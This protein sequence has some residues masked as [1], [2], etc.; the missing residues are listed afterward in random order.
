MEALQ[1]ATPQQPH[2]AWVTCSPSQGISNN[3]ML[4]E[5]TTTI[6][7]MQS[8]YPSFSRRDSSFLLDETDS[9][10]NNITFFN[11]DNTPYPDLALQSPAMYSSPSP[12]QSSDS[13]SNVPNS[14]SRKGR[15]SKSPEK[16]ASTRKEKKRVQNRMAQKSFRKRKQDYVEALEKRIRQLETE[17]DA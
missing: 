11:Q 15:P 16:D 10:N 12:E 5:L 17:L 3:W 4:P 13:L 2:M 7:P 9:H 8:L 6:Q 1:L 14:P